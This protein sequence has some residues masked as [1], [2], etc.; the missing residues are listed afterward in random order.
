MAVMPS[1]KKNRLPAF[2]PKTPVDA[3]R[4]GLHFGQEV[5]IALDVCAAGC[6][7]LGKAELT[8]VARIFVQKPLDGQES[9]EDS[10]RVV[11]TIHSHA[12][13]ERFLPKLFEQSFPESVGGAKIRDL[14]C[15][16]R[17]SHTDRE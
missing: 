6:A 12:Q 7:D 14:A 16:V 10:L 8:V 15:P 3:L 5:V 2:G 9:F 17:G 1:E 4:L 13:V 11:D